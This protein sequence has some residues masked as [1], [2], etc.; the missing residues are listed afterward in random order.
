MPIAIPY[1]RFLKSESPLPI[2]PVDCRTNTPIKLK[3]EAMRKQRTIILKYFII[4]RLM[5]YWCVSTTTDDRLLRRQRTAFEM[6]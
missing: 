2:K 1:G 4:S 5:K 6:N 3:T